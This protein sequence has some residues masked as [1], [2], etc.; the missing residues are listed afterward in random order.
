MANINARS[1]LYHLGYSATP[2][3]FYMFERDYKPHNPKIPHK[4]PKYQ[5]TNKKQKKKLKPNITKQ[6]GKAKTSENLLVA[7]TCQAN[8]CP[9]YNNDTKQNVIIP[10][11]LHSLTQTTIG[12]SQGPQHGVSKKC[13]L[14]YFASQNGD[15]SSSVFKESQIPIWQYLVMKIAVITDSFQQWWFMSFGIQGEP[16]VKEGQ[17]G[18]GQN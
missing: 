2:Y 5:K 16:M 15:A 11:H 12:L 17:G 13:S 9:K 1:C 14:M 7:L 6:C 18:S 4:L 3:V 10:Y 8:S